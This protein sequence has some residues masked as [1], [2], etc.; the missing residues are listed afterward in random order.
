[1]KVLL[2]VFVAVI[3]AAVLISCK[4]FKKKNSTE[5]AGTNNSNNYSLAVKENFIDS[6]NGK[7]VTLFYLKNKNIQAAVTNYG[8]RM[9]NLLVPDKNGQM[10]DVLTGFSSF[11]GFYNSNEP[12]FGALIGRYSNRIAK[13]KFSIDGKEYQLPVNNGVNTLHGGPEGFHNVVWNGQQLTDSSLE[14]TYFSPDG[15]LGFPGNLSVKVI[16]SLTSNG[17]LKID[18]EATVDKKTV[19]NLTNH[20]FWNLNGE[21]SGTINNH[22]LMIKAA[23]YTVV[24]STL[25]PTGIEAVAGTPFDFTSFHKIGERVDSEHTQLAYGNG[26]DHNYVLDKGV[27]D[28][29]Q[30]V[31]TIKGDL[32]GIEMDVLTTEPGLQFYGGNFM[33]GLN[34]MKSGAKDEFRTAF[35]LETH[36][37]PDSPNQPA[38]PSTILDQGKTFKSVTIYKFRK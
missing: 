24:D 12:F 1:M 33:K 14:L 19:V 32:S 31:A 34:I 8:G 29:P 36:H 25:I 5:N 4:R 38:F 3:C 11:K 17:E 27:T 30:L 16:Y 22:E 37:F 28:V 7:P 13:G 9:V 2:I 35:C 10:V 23:K 26:Y 18:Y 21:G 6:L 15:E 20:N